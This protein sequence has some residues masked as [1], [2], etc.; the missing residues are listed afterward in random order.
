MIKKLLYILILF[1]VHSLHAQIFNW[2]NP[3]FQN[4]SIDDHQIIEKLQQD[5][6]LKDTLNY[7]K[8]QKQTVLEDAILAKNRKTKILGE[9]ET[10]GS[11]IRGVTFGNNQGSSVQSSMD[12][13]ING[14]LSKDVSVTASIYDQNLPVQAD[15]YTQTLDEFDKIYIQLD[16]KDKTK[17]KAGHIDLDNNQSY[18][19]RYQRRSMG[20]EFDTQLGTKNKTFLNLSA[21]VARSEFQRMRFQGIEG[22]QGPYRLRGKNNELF[23]SII[24]DSEQVFIDGILM[25]RGE[26]ND[27]IINYNTGE[28]TFTTYR[29]IFQ[30]NYITVSYNYTNRNYSRFLVTGGVNHVREKWNTH[31]NWFIEND[32]KNAPL[33]LNLSEEDKQALALAGNNP[34]L[35]YASSGVITEYD[36]NK[37]LYRKVNNNITDYYEYSTDSNEELYQVDFTFFGN[38]QGDYVIKQTNNNGRIFEYVGQNNG[39]YRAVRK[40]TAPMKTQVFS[41]HSEYL[42]ENGKIGIDFSLSNRDENL[43]SSLDA[44]QNIGYAGRIYAEKTFTHNNWKGTPSLEFQHI[45]KQFYILDRINNVEFSREFNLAQEFNQ[46]TQNRLIF[47]FNNEWKNTS[48]LRYKLNYLNEED[49]YKGIKNETH[50]GWKSGRYNTIGNFSYLSTKGEIENTD[51]IKGEISSTLSKEKGNWSVGASMEHNLRKINLLNQYD[52][53]SFSWKE[54]FVGKKIGDS[55]RTFLEARVYLRDNDSIQNNQLTN[56]NQLLGFQA[57][58][59]IIKTENTTLSSLIHYR[60]FYNQSDNFSTN[61]NQDFVIGNIQLNQN[62][63]NNGLRFQAFYELGNGQEAQREFQYIKV[64]DGQ[65]VY[66][67]TDYNGDGIQQLD[68]FELAEYSDLAQYIRIYSNATRYLPSNKNGLKLSL[69][70]HPAIILKSENSFFK[71]WELNLALNSANS[72]FKNDRALVFNPFEKNEN[73]I[74]KNQS[75]LALVKFRNTANSG[76]NGSYRLIQNNHSILANFSNEGRKQNAHFVNIGFKFN[77]FLNLDWEN[78]IQNTENSSENF[79]TRNYLLNHLETKPKITYLFSRAIQA[80]LSTAYI[81]KERKDGGEILKAYDISGT[82]QWQNKSTSIRAGLSLINNDFTGNNFS[83]VGNQMLNGLKAGKNQ[84]WNVYFQQK[85][86]S[87]IELNINYEGRSSSERTVHIGNMQVKANF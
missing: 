73:Q 52:T 72:F 82:L 3:N 35:M 14:K 9:L 8:Q 60:K 61:T 49:F 74:L 75:L 18:F 58:S 71:R 4:D 45:N 27:Y 7:V 66:K 63:W 6:F 68:E 76:W 57:S 87:F 81:H 47:T 25:K 70:L 28:I 32:N 1:C 48:F 17:L 21:G 85:I 65:G 64:T 44:D 15:G 50:F 84:V 59:E 37:I 16:I 31:F 29:P 10:K 77:E 13:K 83:I 53:N 24:P 23:I 26:K 12:L 86:N 54:V 79:S 33:S 22:N 36:V 55:T 11:I 67:W 62:L 2:K 78:S 19:A 80:E 30:Q 41:T 20:L 39:D 5:T 34:D 69:Y 51:F 43:F 56:V 38:N 42:L 46:K 40:L